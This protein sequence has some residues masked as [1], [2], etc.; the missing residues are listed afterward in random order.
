MNRLRTERISCKIIAYFGEDVKGR[1]QKSP[2]SIRDEAGDYFAVDLTAHHVVLMT[3]T[4]YDFDSSDSLVVVLIRG[5]L[6]VG[7]LRSTSL[8]L[9]VGRLF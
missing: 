2:A 7:V 9:R 3:D 1:A 5:G 6:G 4:I 8:L